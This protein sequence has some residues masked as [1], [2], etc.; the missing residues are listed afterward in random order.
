MDDL[1]K[2]TLINKLKSVY[3]SNHVQERHESSAEHTWSTMMLA[4]YFLEKIKHQLNRQ[5]VLE[6]LLYHDL[7]EIEAG[8]LSLE[9]EEARKKKQKTELAAAKK[10]RKELPRELGE[11]FWD[12]FVEFEEQMTSEAKFA[13]AM[14][15]IDAQLHEI[16][17]K[18]DW[19]GWTRAFLERRNTEENRDAAL[20][21]FPEIAAAFTDILDWLEQEGYFSQ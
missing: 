13:K 2:F 10:L 14:D 4:D 15:I 17:Y 1:L 18:E 16:D 12:C 3:R 9:D 11:K 19:E 20:N 8:D 7:V 6:L 21:E 5:R